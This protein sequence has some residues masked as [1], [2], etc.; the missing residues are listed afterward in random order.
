M[1]EAGPAA[2]AGAAGHW[3][4]HQGPPHGPQRHP[5]SPQ[6][7]LPWRDLPERYGPW[8]T[9]YSRFRRRHLAGVWE[10]VLTSL[11]AE[12]DAEGDLD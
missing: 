11:Q 7:R 10:R 8:Q 9:V 5:A 4:A 12:A 1:N 2:A 6:D 3:P